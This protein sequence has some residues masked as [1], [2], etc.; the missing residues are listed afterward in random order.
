LLKFQIHFF[1]FLFCL[2]GFF[3]MFKC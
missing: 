1:S 3:N 2:R